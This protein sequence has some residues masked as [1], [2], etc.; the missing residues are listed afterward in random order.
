MPTVGGQALATE[1]APL[2][3]PYD[4][5]EN[6]YDRDDC[7]VAV[8]VASLL[9]LI[10]TVPTGVPWVSG[11]AGTAGATACTLFVEEGDD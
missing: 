7:L 2:W 10:V 9:S 1:F 4:Y 5:Q 11:A 3:Q 8:G 6:D